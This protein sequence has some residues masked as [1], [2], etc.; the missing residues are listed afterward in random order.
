MK[1]R[2]RSGKLSNLDVSNIRKQTIP[3]T[4]GLKADYETLELNANIS[5]TDGMTTEDI[6]KIYILSALNLIDVDKPDYVFVAARLNLYDLYHTVRRTYKLPKLKGDIYKQISL[7]DYL[8]FNKNELSYAEKKDLFD[9]DRLNESID[10]RRDLLFT[11]NASETLIS[12]YLL[13]VNG[14]V[15][16][17]PQHFMMSVAMFISQNE[18]NPTDVAIELYE[19]MSLLHFLLATPT[20]ANGRTKNG[21][22]FSCAI[23]SMP[24]DLDG[25]FDSYKEMATGSKYGSGWGY[26]V[27]RIRALGG[28]IQGVRD[29]AN[30]IV[31]PM[32]IVN[33]IAN[34]VDQL[35]V[36]PGAIAVYIES[37]HKDIIDY[38]DMKKNS[39]DEKRRTKELFIA[40]SC[41]DLFMNRVK[42]NEMFTMFDPYDVPELTEIWGKEFEDKYNEYESK[43]LDGSNIFVNKPVQMN[44]KDL[45]KKIQRLYW[46]TGMPFLFFKDNV[47]KAH[48][49]PEEGI[50]RS[51]NLCA[52]IFQPTDYDRTALCNLGSLNLAKVNT[53]EQLE[54]TIR[55]AHRALDNVI[56]V[57]SYPIP[58]TEK[59]QKHTRAV[60]LGVCGEGELIANK[61]IIY[62]SEAHEVYLEELYGNIA[63]ISDKA[64]EELAIE[65]G[66][67][68]EG[69][70]FRNAYR[71][72]NA[73]TSTISILMG[74]TA[75]HEGSFDKVWIE[76]NKLGN[77]KMTAPGINPDNFPF[78]ISPYDAD[79]FGSVRCNA[80]RTKNTDQGTSYNIYFRPGTSGK[81]VYDFIMLAWELGFKSTYY[82][83][84]K[85]IKVKDDSELNE[86]QVK[87]NKI[88]CV[89]CEN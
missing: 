54:K 51:S 40:V 77:V 58:G 14:K 33:D 67:W 6:Q 7:S 57:T 38:L 62:G 81:T 60:G 29:V 87:T 66:P 69:K 18:T 75:M 5:F 10:S 41:S 42:N 56:D 61:Q 52:E 86:L 70:K 72:A 28:T 3:A 46:E 22:C 89:G 37:W 53:L 55:I 76:E 36:R 16:E 68:K 20:L 78:Y 65:R 12:R 31:P 8:E 83:R 84:S 44:A 32:K 11:Y 21:N 15:T 30:G 39:G 88:S 27:T 35:G 48:E 85:G 50:I 17:L 73:P 82:L 64:S 19:E 13:R 43:F 34:Y 71:R 2:K 45:W 24:D 74:T 4:D 1:I 23:G 47:N 63:R 80:V 26:D 25:I 79:P 9:L 59:V 49:N